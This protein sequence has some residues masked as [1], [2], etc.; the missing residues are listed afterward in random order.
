MCSEPKRHNFLHDARR[1]DRWWEEKTTFFVI[2]AKGAPFYCLDCLDPTATH[3]DSPFAPAVSRKQR[4]SYLEGFFRLHTA[5][6]SLS[7]KFEVTRPFRAENKW[8]RQSAGRVGCRAP[9][10][11]H[12]H[13]APSSATDA[14]Q[15]TT[16]RSCHP[17]SAVPRAAMPPTQRGR[18]GRRVGRAKEKARGSSHPPREQAAR[19]A[20]A[21]ALVRGVQLASAPSARLRVGGKAATR[22][23]LL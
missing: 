18:R 10:A 22:D 13:R 8:V 17:A 9:R 12:P 16:R 19:A 3:P 15:G 5:A 20:P 4:D 23:T 11:R 6:S 2:R 1:V 14:N 21:L 7:G